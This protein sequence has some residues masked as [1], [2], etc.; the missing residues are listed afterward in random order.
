MSNATLQ[1]SPSVAASARKLE[2]KVAVVTGGNSGIG[3][4][5]AEEFAA[6]G[7]KVVV[8]GRDEKSLNETRAAL[9][10]HGHAVKGDVAKLADLDRLYAEIK[11]KYGR[12][13]I[14]VANA[15]IAQFFPVEDVTEADFD[16]VFDINVK[17]LFFT[18]QKALPLLSKGSSVILVSSVVKDKGMPHTSIYAGTK[19]AVRTMTRALGAELLPRGIRVNSLSPGAIETPILAR[20]VSAEAAAATKDH[21]AG[22]MPIGRM[23]TAK[24]M[25][26]AALYMASDDSAFMVG[27]D[28]TI[29][30]GFGQF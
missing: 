21:M 16:R 15:G 20:G 29:D 9:G 17:G 10:E 7:A 5:I 4:A 23:G 3:R 8:L 30:G 14:L 24:E 12:V 22:L 11:A 18:V 6:Q 2:G 13:D 25:A 26:A 19:G 28:L 1:S 27:A